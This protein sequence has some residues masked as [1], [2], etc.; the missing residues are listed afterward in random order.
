M[1]RWLI[2]GGSGFLGINLVRY[3]LHKK[4]EVVVLD[5][6]PFDYPE[7]E[8]VAIVQGDIRNR[9]T[10]G[11]AMQN[12]EVVVH[13]AAALPLYSSHD[14][15]STNV[16][17]TKNVAEA[18]LIEKVKRFILISST[19]VYGIKNN[20]SF[21]EDDPLQGIGPYGK[22][23]IQAEKVCEELRQQ[24][25]CVSIIRPKSFVG[26]ERLGVLAIVYDW[27]SS[28]KN[29]PLIGSG[30]NRYQ[31]LDVDDLCQAIWLCTTKP[32]KKVNGVF[33]IAAKEFATMKEDFGAVLEY[34][35]FGKRIVKTPATLVILG[36][37]F[38]ESVG[39]SPIYQ[40]I[41][42]TAAEDFYV[43]T[44]KAELVLGW[45]PRYSNKEALIRNYQWYLAHQ[46]EF[47]GQEGMS[48]RVPWKQGL[49]KFA[50]IF[51]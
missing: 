45:K 50:K 44:E 22:A 17:G 3:L 19:A 46:E 34:A 27:V 10:V 13:A 14:I 48:H 11:R 39:V 7:R 40:W 18:A 21:R 29:I 49:L 42:E 31:L 20:H 37:R 16:Q 15:F 38:L 2:T 25:T 4:Q 9:E 32:K 6:A 8:A 41:Y 43:S 35:G 24:G 1:A 30:T 36:L 33:N 26:P 47:Q 23:K 12:V 28:G 51:F 5:I